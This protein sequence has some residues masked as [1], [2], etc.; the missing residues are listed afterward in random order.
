MLARSFTVLAYDIR[1]HGGTAATPGDY[2]LG[3][4]AQDVIALLDALDIERAHYVGLSLGGMIGQ[5]LGAWHGERLASLVLCATTSD[6][7]KASWGARVREAREAG[8]ASVVEATVDRWA[9]PGFKLRHPD[10]IDQMRAMV[11][12]TSL[13]GYA[14]C[15][16]AIRDMEL[17]AVLG[18]IAVPALVVAGEADTSTPLPVL[19]RI[20]AAIPGA[21]LVKI[22]DAAHMPTMERPEL[23]N[24]ALESF[25]LAVCVTS[26]RDQ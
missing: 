10:V 1:G 22:P 5:Q 8:V 7:P 3:L 26:K 20:A 14:G 11:R 16:A 4:L 15:A 23:C 12:G 17:A 25:L 2:S 21:Q 9:T 13:D 18:R 24:P 6:A 19:E